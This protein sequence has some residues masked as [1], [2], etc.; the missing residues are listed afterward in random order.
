MTALPAWVE[1]ASRQ[2]R[3]YGCGRGYGHAVRAVDGAGV[4]IGN[5]AEA[6]VVA[7]TCG[8]CNAI[9]VVT[10]SGEV[11]QGTAQPPL[12]GDDVLDAHDALVEWEGD[13]VSLLSE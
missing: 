5:V 9:G 2:V 8:S 6:W 7:I 3:C 1:R 11:M 10:I 4:R 13:L 12:S